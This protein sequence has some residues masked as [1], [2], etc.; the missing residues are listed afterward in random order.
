MATFGTRAYN[1]SMTYSCNS[2]SIGLTSRDITIVLATKAQFYRHWLLSDTLVAK[3][4]H[5]QIQLL[6]AT[7][8]TIRAA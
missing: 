2:R 7:M 5:A 8:S 1:C 4:N 3:G 6:R